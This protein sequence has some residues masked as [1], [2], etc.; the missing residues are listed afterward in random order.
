MKRIYFL[1]AL[2]CG[3]MMG[4]SSKGD[5]GKPNEEGNGL[6]EKLTV[7]STLQSHMVIQQ[8][9]PFT[10]SG[11]GTAGDYVEISYSWEEA[12]SRVQVAADGNWRHTVTAPKG[13]FDVQQVK[14][15]GKQTLVFDDILIGEVW[16]CSGQSNMWWPLKD[17]EGGLSEMIA[18]NASLPVRLLQM[19][20][21]QS[22]TPVPTLSA[23]WQPCTAGSLEWFSA[24]AYFFGKQLVDVLQVPV[25]LIDASWGDTT[26]EVWAERDAVLADATIRE[27]ALKQD[28]TPRA[29]TQAP[30]HIG[31]AFNA[32]IYPLRDLSVAGAIWYQG[33]ANMDAPAT[34]PALLSTLVTSWRKLWNV[35]ATDFPFYIAQIC[36][37]QRAFNYLVNYANPAMRFAQQRASD[38]IANS[39]VI[40]NDDIGDILN[41]HPKNKRDVGKRFAFLALADTYGKTGQPRS[42]QYATHR[43]EGNV[44]EVDF[45]NAETGLK[46]TDGTPPTSFELAGEDRVFHPATAVVAGSTVRLTAAEVPQPAYARLGWSYTRTTNL[47]S[48]EGMPVS[49]FKTYDWPDPQ[50]EQ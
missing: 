31:S 20:Q 42:P 47:R 24:V 34:Y 14:V 35:E 8:Q 22:S 12:S 37:Y 39:G 16:L 13:G 43:V 36:P 7:A 28:V 26:A 18:A 30:Y 44:L 9:K 4:C 48:N 17:A 10:V 5:T 38:R 41:I 33:E 23:T 6:S 19:P 11:T 21:T 3:S 46:T 32:M 40:C 45:K 50:E 27:A 1:I 25:G 15:S 49:V 2:L 29:D